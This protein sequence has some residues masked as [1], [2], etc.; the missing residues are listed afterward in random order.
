MAWSDLHCKIIEKTT[1]DNLKDQD[2]QQEPAWL[3]ALLSANKMHMLHDRVRI[4]NVWWY[5]LLVWCIEQNPLRWS[6][7]QTV[8]V[9]DVIVGQWQENRSVSR[10]VFV[11]LNKASA[12]PSFIPICGMAQFLSCTTDFYLQISRCDLPILCFVMPVHVRHLLNWPKSNLNMNSCALGVERYQAHPRDNKL[13][14][15]LPKS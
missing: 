11:C 12:S 10:K 5:G 2:S 8:E 13:L 9:M 1:T 7:I 15:Y 3:S 4:T 6:C 14:L